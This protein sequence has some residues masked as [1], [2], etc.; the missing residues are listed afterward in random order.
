[1]NP[2]GRP[3]LGKHELSITG[4]RRV[5]EAFTGSPRTTRSPKAHVA[6]NVHDVSVTIAEA[7]GRHRDNQS[8]AQRE[9]KIC[10][11]GVRRRR[12]ELRCEGTPDISRA[13]FP[14]FNAMED[15]LNTQYF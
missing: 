9:E 7:S 3:P 4:G 1:M 14:A 10:S 12:A 5:R 8:A 13:H 11:A 15:I 2:V 6:L